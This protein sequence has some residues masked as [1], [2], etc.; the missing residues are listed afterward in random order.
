MS[1]SKKRQ[2]NIKRIK[3]LLN[4]ADWP[5]LADDNIGIVFLYRMSFNYLIVMEMMQLA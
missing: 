1:V 3:R 4:P 2:A 5:S